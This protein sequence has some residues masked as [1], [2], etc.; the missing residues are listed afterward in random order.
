M[1]RLA[2]LL[3]T[4]CSALAAP[5]PAIIMN[6]IT[7]KFDNVGTVVIMTEN[8][9]EQIPIDE[10]IISDTDI[11]IKSGYIILPKQFG[12]KKTI[13]LPKDCN[14][15]VAPDNI[16]SIDG[17]INTKGSIEN[18]ICTIKSKNEN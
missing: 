16:L 2:I 3:L 14:I 13:S 4:L 6:N 1:Q 8:S 11:Q 12:H 7:S 17:K 15:N 9:E 18:F 10:W 5:H